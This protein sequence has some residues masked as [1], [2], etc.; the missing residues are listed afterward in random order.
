M[1]V[2]RNVYVIIIYKNIIYLLKGCVRG[3]IA[4]ISVLESTYLK[5]FFRHVSQ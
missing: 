2:E 5:I 1:I 3:T 4:K